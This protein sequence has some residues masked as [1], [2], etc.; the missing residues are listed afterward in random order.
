MLVFTADDFLAAEATDRPDPTLLA[1]PD[2]EIVIKKMQTVPEK[3]IMQ[4]QESILK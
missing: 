1:L 4:K 3:R 2:C